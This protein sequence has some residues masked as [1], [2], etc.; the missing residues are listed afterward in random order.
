MSLNDF[1]TVP[2]PEYEEMKKKLEILD[3]IMK[4]GI[5]TVCSSC[6]KI[7][8]NK[9]DQD[10]YVNMEKFL[11]EVFKVN[12]SYGLCNGCIRKLHP[13]YAESVIED[14]SK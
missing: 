11:E 12:I 10:S 13:D 1:V 4:E 7:K 2:V 8:F 6:G 9:D 14:I 5:I 3:N